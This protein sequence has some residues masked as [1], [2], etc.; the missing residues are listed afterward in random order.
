MKKEE[1]KK[2]IDSIQVPKE[3]LEYLTIEKQHSFSI[4]RLALICTLLFAIGIGLLPNKTNEKYSYTTIVS[5]YGQSNTLENPI[6]LMIPSTV[7]KDEFRSS[8]GYD[9]VKQEYV[10]IGKIPFDV[11]IEGENIKEIHYR[12]FSNEGSSMTLFT[13]LSEEQICP[14]YKDDEYIIHK[15]YD[16]YNEEAK[17]IAFEYFN[18]LENDTPIEIFE[19]LYN[20]DNKDNPAVASLYWLRKSDYK[21]IKLAYQ[22]QYNHKTKIELWI[23][24][25]L[26]PEESQLDNINDLLNKTIENLTNVS[27]QVDIIYK[28]EKKITKTI[29]FKKEKDYCIL[30]IK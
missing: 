26:T 20:S 18:I 17:Q 10:L 13:E 14:P 3:K 22:D 1:F 7:L 16:E 30:K 2:A 21:E 11:R 12:L 15:Q 28:N 29:S 5:A 23:K 24:S 8:Y 19:K 27:I 25:K 9:E 6:D 4:K